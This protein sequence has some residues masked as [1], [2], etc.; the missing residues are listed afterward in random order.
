MCAKV[1]KNRDDLIFSNIPD[2]YLK[3]I[4]AP[5]N[6]KSEVLPALHVK[7]ENLRGTVKSLDDL[8]RS[9]LANVQ[10]PLSSLKAS[11]FLSAFEELKAL[12]ES[13]SEAQKAWEELEK[14]YGK[15]TSAFLKD[16]LYP[17]I[18]GMLDE[19]LIIDDSTL[20]EGIGAA[21]QQKEKE[22]ESHLRFVNDTITPLLNAIVNELA[23]VDGTLKKK[24]EKNSFQAALELMPSQKSVES[25]DVKQPELAAAKLGYEFAQNLL[26]QMSETADFVDYVDKRSNLQSKKKELQEEYDKHLSEYNQLK[27]EMDEIAGLYVVDDVAD[28]YYRLVEP[29]KERLNEYYTSLKSKK[30]VPADF[31]SALDE[32]DSYLKELKLIWR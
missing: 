30:D 10:P 6:V 18:K 32:L 4:S 7:A 9:K 26:K 17:V 8:L 1:K 3:L 25:I 23:N 11:G 28:F 27:A 19:L 12:K 31:F 22:V 21:C 13:D 20:T 24:L 16:S 2:Q 15:K 5:V 14:E 29:V